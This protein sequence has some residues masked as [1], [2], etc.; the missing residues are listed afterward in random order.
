MRT[1]GRALV[2]N[3]FSLDIRP[4]VRAGAIRYG[5]YAEGTMELPGDDKSFALT[6]EVSTRDRANCWMRVRGTI[7]DWWSGRRDIDDEFSVDTVRHPGGGRRWCFVCPRLGYRVRKLY[8]PR[9]ARQFRSRQ[10]YNLAYETEH[11]D[12]RER[13]WRRIRKCRQQLGSDPSGIDKPYPEKP[14]GMS[15]TRYARLIDRLDDAEN[16]LDLPMT[17]GGPRFA[18]RPDRHGLRGRP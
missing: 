13:G 3:T 8:L 1:G 5:L 16:D 12:D 18:H 7:P 9:G 14:A 2:E 4:L 11:L 10:A 15:A 17:L 6:F